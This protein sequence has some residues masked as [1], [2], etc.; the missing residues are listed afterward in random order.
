MFNL[1]CY[2]MILFFAISHFIVKLIEQCL[3]LQSSVMPHVLCFFNLISGD[4]S[5]DPQWGS[6]YN[7]GVKK[8]Q[9]AIVSS[10]LEDSKL[11]GSFQEGCNEKINTVA[12]FIYSAHFIFRGAVHM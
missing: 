9:Y 3:E 1:V 2:D 7:F 6:L 11:L 10:N 5:L 12:V 8:K 4:F